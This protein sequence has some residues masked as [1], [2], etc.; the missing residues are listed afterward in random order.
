MRFF[1]VRF[2]K[3]YFNDTHPGIY[4]EAIVA[5]SKRPYEQRLWTPQ[6]SFDGRPPVGTP[7]RATRFMYRIILDLWLIKVK[8]EWIGGWHEERETTD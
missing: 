7:E 1:E 8:F 5:Y 3:L 2:P 4:P 6:F